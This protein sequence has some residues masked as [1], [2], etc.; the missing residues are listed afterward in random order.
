MPGPEFSGGGEKAVG[1]LI[2][3][4]PFRLIR[5]Q[6]VDEL[7]VVRDFA[8]EEDRRALALEIAQAW[9]M[10]AIADQCLNLLVEMARNLGRIRGN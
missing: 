1:P 10:L 7:Q 5:P 4:D 2:F 3:A 8:L 6:R 9:Q